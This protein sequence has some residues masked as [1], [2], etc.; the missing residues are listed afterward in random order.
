MSDYRRTTRECSVS[1]LQPAL[2]DAIQA[3]LAQYELGD[4]LSE[5]LICAETR[6]ELKAKGIFAW[7]SAAT[8]GADRDPAHYTAVIVTPQWFIGARAGSPGNRRG[9][10]AVTA[11]LRD[12][13][14][15]DYSM[16]HLVEDEGFETFGLMTDMTERVDL[17]WGLGAEPAALRLRETLKEAVG[18]AKTP[19]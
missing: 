5:A 14:V 11:R 12:L 8:T 6:N 13:D 2:R 19:P 3:H 4:L 15:R 17:F 10:Y 18:R 9:T 7:L 1:A 16:G